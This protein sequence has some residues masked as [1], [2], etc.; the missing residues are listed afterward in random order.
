MLSIIPSIFKSALPLTVAV[1]PL[2]LAA[3]EPPAFDAVGACS[4]DE[5][6]SLTTGIQRPIDF[7]AIPVAQPAD[8]VTRVLVTSEQEVASFLGDRQ[9]PTSQVLLDNSHEFDPAS[10]DRFS[11]S[12]AAM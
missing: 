8:T 4:L 5:T 10:S 12:P 9:P 6:G 2:L 11:D 7:S 3:A 1:A